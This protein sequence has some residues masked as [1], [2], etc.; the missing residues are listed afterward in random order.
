MRKNLFGIIFAVLACLAAVQ[1]NAAVTLGNTDAT[2]AIATAW[3]YT[4]MIGTF[5]TATVSFQGDTVY[6]YFPSGYAGSAAVAVYLTGSGGAS[7]YTLQAYSNS[8]SYS[9]NGWVALSLLAPVNVTA[10]QTYFLSVISSSSVYELT[11]GGSGSTG[12][13]Y[14]TGYNP[15]SFPNFSSPISVTFNNSGGLSIYLSSP[16]GTPTFTPTFTPT[17]T[18]TP[19]ATATSSMTP[20]GTPT[21][22]ATPSGTPT[23]TATPSSTASPVFTASDTPTFTATPS[24]T[25]TGTGTPTF[26]PTVTPTATIS[27]TATASPTITPTFTVSLTVTMTKIPSATPT[28]TPFSTDPDFVQAY[29]V[30]A[31]GRDVWFTFF[32]KGP[33]RASIDIYNVSGEKVHTLSSSYPGGTRFAH[34]DIQNAAPG[35]Y[36]YR[37][38]IEDTSGTRNFAVKK[39]VVVK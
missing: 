27:P 3:S 34:W 25:R 37:V 18:A 12:S 17:Y 33:G 32:I 1:G 7:P 39:L 20:S 21:R 16:I 30:P 5:F 14:Y 8:Q 31:K 10:G 22:T 38:T 19:T 36:L 4:Y 24:V 29:P 2:G 13:V 28:L 15:A 9:G 23:Y 26:T 11:Y 35:I 6:V